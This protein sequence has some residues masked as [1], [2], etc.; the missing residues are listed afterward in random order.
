[1]GSQRM[2]LM[3][4]PR[5]GYLSFGQGIVSRLTTLKI[6]QNLTVQQTICSLKQMMTFSFEDAV[7]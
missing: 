3:S 1:M 2:E 6:H 5:G 4:V 7:K